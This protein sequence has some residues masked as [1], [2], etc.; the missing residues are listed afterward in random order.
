METKKL[1]YEDKLFY[2]LGF[3]PI[4]IKI[5]LLIFIPKY[6]GEITAVDI[7]ISIIV[8]IS[9][10][11]YADKDADDLSV[12]YFCMAGAKLIFSILF[13]LVALI[14][15]GGLE[16]DLK[17]TLKIPS[18]ILILALTDG[19]AANILLLITGPIED[20]FDNLKNRKENKEQ[21]KFNRTIDRA[22]S[23]IIE[24]LRDARLKLYRLK[25]DMEDAA[26]GF[27]YNDRMIIAKTTLLIYVMA[28]SHIQPL[29]TKKLAKSVD[30]NEDD[31]VYLDEAFVSEGLE[32]LHVI[33]PII[34]YN[35]IEYGKN[36]VKMLNS[37]EDK[38]E[39]V[40]DELL[41]NL[42]KDTENI[43]KEI[44]AVKENE[45]KKNLEKLTEEAK[46][47]IRRLA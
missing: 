7:V 18:T 8:I 44:S 4:L 32:V 28:N 5:I 9:L 37:I 25:R 29:D 15:E 19:V 35:M 12:E 41:S 16:S 36:Y 3:L 21:E 2:L 17:S 23:R 39:G 20:L 38:T 31:Y 24:E 40:N 26:F 34:F 11:V 47:D 42:Y 14:I 13:I 27:S 46:L 43:Y 22:T 33:N 1:G 45:R 30:L 6:F 10:R